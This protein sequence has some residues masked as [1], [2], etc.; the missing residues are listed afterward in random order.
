MIKFYHI[1]KCNNCG[2]A[3]FI[4]ED[5]KTR[6]CPKCNKKLKC[7]QLK[8]LDKAQSPLEAVQIVQSMKISNKFEKKIDIIK[9]QLQGPKKSS[10]EKIFGDLISGLI[11]L[12]P[13]NIPKQYLLDQAIKMD[14]LE[15][16][17]ENLLEKLHE[18]GLVIINRDFRPGN[19]DIVLKFPS[20]PFSVGK[21]TVKKSKSVK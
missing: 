6:F 18:A 16:D 17:V 5:Q 20:I 7:N 12:F 4:R 13:N 8:V 1:V 2:L 15:E 19:N 11:P 10:K 21:I 14:L 3:Q 9:S